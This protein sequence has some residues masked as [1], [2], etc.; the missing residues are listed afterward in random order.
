[1]SKNKQPVV[2]NI[3]HLNME[4]D[5]D[6][7]ADAIV[8]A[9]N[10]TQGDNAIISNTFSFLSSAFLNLLAI[11]GMVFS[12]GT[13]VGV[14]YYAINYMVWLSFKSYVSNMY[15]IIM[16]MLISAVLGLFSWK[17]GRAAKAIESER[18]KQFIISVFSG[19]ASFAAVIV[20]LVALIKG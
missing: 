9:Q 16:F 12:V 7:L 13:L 11:I 10:K 19:L 20:A 6:K 3:G 15:V 5:Y 14:V 18:D 17:L 4:I 8:R 2:N 1:M